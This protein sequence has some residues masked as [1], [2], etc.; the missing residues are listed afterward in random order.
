MLVLN[1]CEIGSG[2]AEWA[3]HAGR[4][5]KR[6]YTR[7]TPLNSHK[8]VICINH[9]IILK[10]LLILY[11]LIRLPFFHLA[12]LNFVKERVRVATSSKLGSYCLL[13][14][15]FDIDA[16]SVVLNLIAEA[17][18]AASTY[19]PYLKLAE[20][21]CWIEIESFPSRPNKMLRT[22]HLSFQISNCGLL[23]I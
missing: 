20:A 7:P 5:T 4:A 23:Q 14:K 10:L 15:L 16:A 21:H 2:S 6:P 18:T 22:F 13:C 3:N 8:C 19:I 11:R 9:K 1:W 17:L 12:V